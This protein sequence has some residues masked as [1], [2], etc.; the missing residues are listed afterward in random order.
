MK[1]SNILQQDQGVG[2]V[3]SLLWFKRYLPAECCKFLEMVLM[4]CADHGP[5]V[6]G[7]HNAIVCSRAGKD[8][9]DSLC[10]GLLT[11]GPRFGGAL[12]MA[13]KSFSKAFDSGILPNE[14]VNDMK[15]RNELVMGI[16]HRIK[17]KTNPDK[18]VEL[19][20]DYCINV[21]KWSSTSITDSVLGYALGVEEVT[22]KKKANLILN[23][24][25]AIA[26]AFVDMVRKC[27]AFSLEEATE[28][29]ECG[30]LNGLFVL[31]RSIGLIG[32]VLDQKRMGQALYRH[33][34]DDIA[35]INADSG[36]SGQ[37]AAGAR[38][39][40]S[41]AEARQSHRAGSTESARKAARIVGRADSM[42]D[43]SGQ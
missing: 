40:N 8:V 2:S 24:D 13:A 23:V 42:V 7:A 21:A 17:S 25:G 9:V 11:I 6:S 36:N 39:R 28:M 30:C 41:S 29:V 5:A 22:I 4:I 20:K 1:L 26:S 14:Y 31:S 12:D 15:K 34:F 35:Y 37:G 33:P 38:G 32:H 16:G 10:S 19:I 43:L 27:K 18:R 3:I